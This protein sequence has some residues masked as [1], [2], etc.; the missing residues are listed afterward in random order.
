MSAPS[1]GQF[2]LDNQHILLLLIYTNQYFII[3]IL[4]INHAP[5]NFYGDN[6]ASVFYYLNCEAHG[7]NMF[8]TLIT[9][10]PYVYIIGNLPTGLWPV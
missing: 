4:N 9:R 10:M 7:F 1:V 5:Y 3:S 8:T 6:A 2:L